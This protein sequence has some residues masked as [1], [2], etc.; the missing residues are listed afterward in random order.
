MN[1]LKRDYIISLNRKKITKIL[2]SREQ[3]IA[4]QIEPYAQGTQS[5]KQKS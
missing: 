3:G 4:I 5:P 1:F 2:E